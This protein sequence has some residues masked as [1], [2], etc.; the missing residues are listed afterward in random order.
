VFA[1][2]LATAVVLGFRYPV[3]WA[4]VLLTKVAP[5]VGLL[6]FVVR[7]EWR[8]QATVALATV[9]VS[10]VS[11]FP[12]PGLWMEWDPVAAAECFHSCQ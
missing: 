12:A 11:F 1:V 10:G 3:T 5:G 2:L 6:W 8:N 9:M 7:R 4:F